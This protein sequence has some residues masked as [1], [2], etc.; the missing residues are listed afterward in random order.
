MT[1]RNC[2][3]RRTTRQGV[4]LLFV[5]VVFAVISVMLTE[6][7][8]HAGA[9][10]KFLEIRNNQLQAAWLTRAGAEWAADRLLNDKKYEGETVDLTA[11]GRVIIK[12]EG[13]GMDEFRIR[14]GAKYPMDGVRPV[15]LETTRIARR[16]TQDGK[17]RIDLGAP[18]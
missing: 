13:T 7:A 2:D 14:C 11:G 18:E 8:R 10:R 12:V 15:S 1:V 4:A 9:C 3:R 16:I 6:S 5:L 17:T